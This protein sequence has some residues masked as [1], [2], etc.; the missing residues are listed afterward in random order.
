VNEVKLQRRKL[1]SL[2]RGSAYR[3]QMVCQLSPTFFGQSAKLDPVP[4]LRMTRKVCENATSNIYFSQRAPKL[5]L[6]RPPL[7]D[8]I[9]HTTVWL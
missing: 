8:P 2:L 6:L 4:E 7:D 9:R 3:F 1:R 5:S